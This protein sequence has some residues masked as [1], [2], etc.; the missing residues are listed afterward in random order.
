MVIVVVMVV[1]IVVVV[2]IV[3]VNS[4][5]KL[6]IEQR[7]K[8]PKAQSCL[9]FIYFIHFFSIHA[10]KHTSHFLVNLKLL[11]NDHACQHRR[12]HH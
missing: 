8:L 11:I 12:R 2:I 1:V 6:I 9:F 10:L 3:I 7:S 5:I 4:K